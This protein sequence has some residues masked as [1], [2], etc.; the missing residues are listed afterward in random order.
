MSSWADVSSAVAGAVVFILGALVPRFIAVAELWM[1]KLGDGKTAPA[2][3][4]TAP[5]AQ[6]SPTTSESPNPETPQ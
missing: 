5:P 3:A 2:T 1:D 6:P 4:T